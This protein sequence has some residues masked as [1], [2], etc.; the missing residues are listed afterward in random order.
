MRAIMMTAVGNSDVLQLQ[1]CPS[2]KIRH[3]SEVKIKLRAAGINP[4]DTK[5][6]RHGVFYGNTLPAILGCDGAGEVIE[7]GS[8]VTHFQVGDKVWFCHGGLGRE[9]GNYAEYTVVD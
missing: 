8:A 1:D 3:A 7:I 2:P 4:I 9:Q 6:R 5:L